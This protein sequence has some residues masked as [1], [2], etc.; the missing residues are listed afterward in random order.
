[1]ARQER[2]LR[3]RLV[4]RF[5][6]PRGGQVLLRLLQVVERDTRLRGAGV[7]IGVAALVQFNFAIEVRS[8]GIQ[9]AQ[10]ELAIQHLS[11]HG[12]PSRCSSVIA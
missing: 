12:R 10:E 7:G 11:N 5:V 2:G 1:M 4:R 8:E 6:R 3:T 9:V